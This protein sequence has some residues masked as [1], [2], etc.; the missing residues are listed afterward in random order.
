MK[1]R[2]WRRC[3]QAKYCDRRA[4]YLVST[5]DLLFPSFSCHEH[6]GDICLQVV[7]LLGEQAIIHAIDD[8]GFT[9]SPKRDEI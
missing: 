9:A 4:A 7:T 3:D 5:P 2:H 8:E 6:L 1:Y